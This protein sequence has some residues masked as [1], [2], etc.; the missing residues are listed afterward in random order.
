MKKEHESIEIMAQKMMKVRVEPY[1]V[2][3][4]V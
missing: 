4:V 1:V 2:P 3:I